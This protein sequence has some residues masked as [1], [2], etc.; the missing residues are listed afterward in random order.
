MILCLPW[1]L[2]AFVCGILL[3][4][5]VKKVKKKPACPT[6]GWREWV[7]LPGLG[8]AAVK[9]KI[10][11]GARSSA[12]HAF[13]METFDRDG[14]TTVRFQVHPWQRN[15]RKTISVE[16]PLAGWRWIR[17][18][19]GHKTL[20]PVIVTDLHLMGLNWPIELTLIGRDEM[21]F[22][23]LLGRQALGLRC[24]IDPA[25]SYLAGKPRRKLRG[26]RK[27]GRAATPP[28][29]KKQESR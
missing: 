28:D 19:S 23:M 21:G 16:H 22:R 20:R 2:C 4:V 15:T 12:L 11:S 24:L 29:A 6:V 9:A 17:S 3:V 13:N 7:A 14:E 18:S 27:K 1:R 8:V 5:R 10:D 26:V 25:R